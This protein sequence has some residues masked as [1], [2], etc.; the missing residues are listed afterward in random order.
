M[1]G[2]DGG[3]GVPPF[4]AWMRPRSETTTT[5]GICPAISGTT[6]YSLCWLSPVGGFVSFKPNSKLKERKVFQT[7]TFLSRSPVLLLS[8]SMQPTMHSQK[9]P[10]PGAWAC[11]DD[12]RHMAV[13]PRYYDK[14]QSQRGLLL[15]PESGPKITQLGIDALL[16]RPRGPLPRVLQGHTD[17]LAGASAPL[18]RGGKSQNAIRKT[19]FVESCAH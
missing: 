4:W 5:T 14:S 11:L 16:H 6:P 2:N 9:E 17:V 19:H 12:G 7:N 1:T 8:F 3:G 10:G 15:R 18:V 13:L